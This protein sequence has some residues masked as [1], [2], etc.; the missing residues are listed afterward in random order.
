MCHVNEIL[1][2]WFGEYDAAGVPSD[3]KMKSWWIKNS[4]FDQRIKNKFLQDVQKAVAGDYDEWLADPRGRLAVIILLDQFTRN[5]YRN[6]N[7]AFSNDQQALQ[8]AL[9][10]LEQGHDK[11]LSWFERVF[12]YMPL[13]HAEDKNI[14]ARCVALYEQLVRDA[15]DSL[16]EHMQNFLNFANAHRHIIDRFGRFPHRNKTLGRTS[17]KEELEF[18]KESGSSF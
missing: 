18:L 7:Q 14:Q 16:Q 1:I 17:T 5:I 11:E 12:F 13:E 15:P 3:D 9:D 8:I 10:G 2:F 4:G 6:T